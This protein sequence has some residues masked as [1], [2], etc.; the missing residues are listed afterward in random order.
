VTA[1]SFS[2]NWAA[3]LAIVFGLLVVAL[4]AIVWVIREHRGR[5]LRVGLFVERDVEQPDRRSSPPDDQR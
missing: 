4:I 1:D 3:L 2:L 5:R